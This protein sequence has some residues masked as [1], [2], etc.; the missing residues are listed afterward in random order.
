MGADS[1]EGEELGG[2]G[3]LSLVW[4]LG[5]YPSTTALPLL[6]RH[7]IWAFGKD[8]G[9]GWTLRVPLQTKCYPLNPD[10]LILQTQRSL[11]ETIESFKLTNQELLRKGSGNS[12]EAATCDAACKVLAPSPPQPRTGR[13]LCLSAPDAPQE[14]ALPPGSCEGQIPAL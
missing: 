5:L 7:C 12:Q 8:R 10:F 14:P 13:C 1:Q 3:R 9:P 2:H 11:Q 4:V 6:R